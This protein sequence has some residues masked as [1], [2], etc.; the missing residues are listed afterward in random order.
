MATKK[1]LFTST[2]RIKDIIIFMFDAARIKNTNISP[3]IYLY[4][5]IYILGKKIYICIYIINIYS[6]IFPPSLRQLEFHA[7]CLNEQ[8][9]K[10]WNTWNKFWWVFPSRV[11][12]LLLLLDCSID[13][14]QFY[15]C[16]SS[17]LKFD[18]K[19]WK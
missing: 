2:A 8:T 16:F 15:C 19:I 5:N 11:E 13:C 3:N 4:L 7:D 9:T 12:S 1:L 17:I 10:K 6:Y 14:V 18:L